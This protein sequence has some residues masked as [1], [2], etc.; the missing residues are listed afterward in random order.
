MQDAVGCDSLGDI[1]DEIY[2]SIRQSTVYPAR[3]F[4]L[5]RGVWPFT[6]RADRTA[7]LLKRPFS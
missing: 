4:A 2:I 7:F 1:E 3:T 5:T 6:R